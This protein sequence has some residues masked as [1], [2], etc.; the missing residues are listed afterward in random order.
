MTDKKYNGWTN[1]ETWNWNLHYDNAF[2]DD[3]QATYDAAEACKTFTKEQNA[4]LTLA[5]YMKQ[6][7]EEE[8]EQVVDAINKSYPQ[9]FFIDAMNAS[10]SEINFYE[11]AEHYID[12]VEKE[13]ASPARETA[14]SIAR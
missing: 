12:E 4:A 7:A 6:Y 3:A 13:A 8:L 14:S 9:S 11:I 2:E 10:L 5:D 1:W